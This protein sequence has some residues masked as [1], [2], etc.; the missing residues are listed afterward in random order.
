MNTHLLYNIT[1]HYNNVNTIL[2]IL[3]APLTFQTVA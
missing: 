1:L 3:G 2:A